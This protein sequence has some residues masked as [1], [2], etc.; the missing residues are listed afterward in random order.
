[1]TAAE[2]ETA[3][4]AR[5]GITT[6][7]LRAMGRVVRSCACGEAECEG[8]QSVSDTDAG[9]AS[10][11]I[12]GGLSLVAKATGNVDEAVVEA[13]NGHIMRHRAAFLGI[14]S[15]AICGEDEICTRP[16]GHEGDH[17]ALWRGE[18]WTAGVEFTMRKRWLGASIRFERATQPQP[19]PRPPRR[20]PPGLAE[21]LRKAAAK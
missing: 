6:D 5:S 4:A 13:V 1:M 15:D 18:T 10:A 17:V 12:G 21:L 14:A 20:P 9:T 3:Y 8:W 19:A 7:Q 16:P 11:D 2:F